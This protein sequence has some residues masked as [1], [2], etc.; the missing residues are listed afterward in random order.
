MKSKGPVYLF[1]FLLLIFHKSLTGQDKIDIGIFESP[2]QDTLVLK[3]RP[4]YTIPAGYYITNIVFTIKWPETS[5]VTQLQNIVSTVN[6]YYQI[7]PQQFSVNGGYRY[8]VYS[9]VGAKN[10]TWSANQEYPVLEIRVNYPGGCTNLEIANDSYTNFVLNGAYY[11]SITGSNKTGIR[12]Q[13]SVS[14]ISQ[15]GVVTPDESICLGS[16]TS[17]MVLSGYSG[18]ILM[19]QKKHDS[20]GWINISGT[21]GMWEYFTTPDSSGTY[22][23]R[24]VVKRGSCDTA[25]STANVVGVAANSVWT[26]SADTLWH[27]PSNWNACGVPA[28]SR[29]VEIPAVAGGLYPA[30]TAPGVCKSLLI[31]SGATLKLKGSGSLDIDGTLV[32]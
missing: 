20:F 9:M 29:D 8:Q 21:A 22:R 15:G 13:P 12:Y 11:I 23:Y 1:I 17:V 14:L 5:P 2:V 25:Y 6:S 27:N 26:G 24:A 7:T 16:S 28:A 4:N 32:K 10:V 3:C 30:I 31:R 18:N 19:W